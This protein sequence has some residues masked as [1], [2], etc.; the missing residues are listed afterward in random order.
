MKKSEIFIFAIAL[1]FFVIG[2]CLYPLMPEKMATHWNSKGEVDG[3]L[4]KFWGLFLLPLIFT[5]VA[6]L[7]IAVPRIDPLKANIEEFREYYDKFIII[8][9]IFFLVIYLHTI[10]WNLGIQISPLLIFPTGIGFML[11]YAGVLCEKAKRNWFIGIRTPWTLSNDR[12]WEKTHKVGGRLFKIIGIVAI[13]GVFVQEYVFV[14]ILTSVI[15]VAVYTVVYSYIEYQRENKA[16][17]VKDE[18]VQSP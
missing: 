14:L 9:S 12:V 1:L 18:A 4:S 17:T 3:Y 13:L 6:L 11:F 2:V 5:G 16:K 7:L 15:L 10:L 8:F